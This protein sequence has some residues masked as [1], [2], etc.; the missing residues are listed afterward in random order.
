MG[1]ILFIIVAV[2]VV[3]GCFVVFCHMDCEPPE[4]SVYDN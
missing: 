1:F 2:I 3:G 4:T